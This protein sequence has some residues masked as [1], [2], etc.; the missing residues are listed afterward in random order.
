M[1]REGF[2]NRKAQDAAA[3]QGI[4]FGADPH[5]RMNLDTI[6][7]SRKAKRAHSNV[8]RSHTPTLTRVADGV[9]G[10]KVRE[11]I[12]SSGFSVSCSIS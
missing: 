4:S 11:G 12:N 10:G 2:G 7:P 3:S 8:I 9:E 1:V 6:N 5:H